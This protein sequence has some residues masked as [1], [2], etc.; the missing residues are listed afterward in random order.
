[1]STD[2]KI[3]LVCVEC[4]RKNGG[5]W[6]EGTHG[7]ALIAECHCCG[8]LTAVTHATNWR[9][10]ERKPVKDWVSSAVL[11]TAEGDFDFPTTKRPVGRPPKV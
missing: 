2:K 8:R 3:Q 9:L 7:T 5:Q 1:M 6:R 10:L 11:E 4:A